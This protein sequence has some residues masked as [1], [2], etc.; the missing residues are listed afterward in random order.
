MKRIIVVIIIAILISAVFIGKF[1]WMEM[2]KR[3]ADDAYWNARYFEDMGKGDLEMKEKAGEFYQKSLDFYSEHAKANHARARVFAIIYGNYNRSYGELLKAHRKDPQDLEIV[4]DL[5]YACKNSGRWDE[6]I[7]CFDSIERLDPESSSAYSGRGSV[8]RDMEE[9]GKA[10]EEFKKAY[11][12]FQGF[13]LLYQIG[14]CY[15]AMEDYSN[16]ARYY[17]MLVEER[18]CSGYY[19]RLGDAY[20]GAKE[21]DKAT[22]AYNEAFVYN[23]EN[24]LAFLGLG[25]IQLEKKN[26]QESLGF[27]EKARNLDPKNKNIQRY[28]E[29]VMEHLS[30]NT[31]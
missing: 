15:M 6:A 7:K 22:S 27:L 29:E 4:K 31:G 25:I 13:G 14:N 17:M 16:A 23:P 21:Y 10:I 2:K 9:Y 11:E 30:E 12:K 3:M 8:Y 20:C 26:Y 18:P 1:G 5:G 24:S 19:R 28:Y